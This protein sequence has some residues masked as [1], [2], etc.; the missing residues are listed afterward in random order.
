MSKSIFLMSVDNQKLLLNFEKTVKKKIKTKKLSQFKIPSSIKKIKNISVWG[1]NSTLENQRLWKK[2]KEGDIILFL[3]DKK[4]FCRCKVIERFD[5]LEIAKKFWVN[6]IFGQTRNLLIFIDQIE[7]INLDFYASIPIFVNPTMPE[8]YRFPI[9]KIDSGRQ[10]ILVNTF[11]DMERAVDFLCGNTKTDF[12]YPEEEIE[13][14]IKEVMTKIR[15]GQEKFRKIIL[16]NYFSRCAVCSISEVDLLQASHIIPVNQK[17]VMGSIRNGICLC[18]LHHLMFDKGYFSFDDNHKIIIAE[19][20]FS[21]K[22]LL[23]KMKYFKKIGKS[24]I[25]P[26]IDFLQMH[27]ARFGIS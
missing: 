15:K 16:D 24:K 6:E 5:S 14:E 13:I 11:G 23:T 1:L 21:T 18:A 7:P 26:S 10:K 9:I 20:K 27:R 25:E 12:D 4:Y 8:S 22:N 17:Q 19:E 3:K 2:I